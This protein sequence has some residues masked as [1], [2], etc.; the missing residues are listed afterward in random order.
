VGIAK[1]D[2]KY[3]FRSFKGFSISVHETDATT[4]VSTTARRASL[5]CEVKDRREP[6]LRM[7]KMAK[8]CM[9]GW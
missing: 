2:Q 9:N 5:D 4:S 3:R 1:P 8:A 7:R 6:K